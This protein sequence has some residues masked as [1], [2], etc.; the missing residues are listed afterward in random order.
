MSK[1]VMLIRASDDESWIAL[2]DDQI[3]Q[4]RLIEHQSREQIKG[5]IYKAKVVQIQTAVQAA[6][7]DYGAKRHGFLPLAEVNAE[8]A[9]PAHQ[10]RGGGRLKVGQQ[11][12]VQV[13]REEVDN[14]GAALTMNIT[15]PG[16]F[17]VMMP[18]CSKGGVSKKIEDKEERERLKGFLTGLENEEHAVIIR[19]A[20]VGRELTE[21]KKDYTQVK[22]HWEDI[23]QT[24]LDAPKVGLIEEEEDVVVRT[25]RDY[26]TEDIDEIWADNPMVF[27]K[28]LD[29]LK[30]CSPRKQKILKL[31]VG[32]RSLF[33]TYNIE[34]QV[35]Q[36][37]AREVRLKSGG[38]VVIDQTEALVAIDVNSGRSNQESTVENTALRTNLEAADEVARQLRLRNLGGI[39]V[40]DFIDME[41]S[42]HR[43]QVEER[44]AMAMSRDRAQHKMGEISEFGIM[45]LSRQRM[46]QRI[47]SVVEST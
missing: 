30:V 6:F 9:D 31:Y 37:T 38:S 42:A 29:F 2:D 20:G 27:Q 25:L 22:K 1:K 11:I 18:H 4:E 39:V 46:A 17:L 36:L 40:V 32:D 34:K 8:L 3:L 23:F 5:N 26:Y 10:G 41:K 44:I 24:F 14:K 15:L 19:T 13:T 35:E 16:R 21:L 7:V 12:L 43:R 45:E 28:V 33:S 47:S